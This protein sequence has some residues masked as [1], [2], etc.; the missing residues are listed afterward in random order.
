MV[1]LKKE[2]IEIAGKMVYNRACLEQDTCVP[3]EGVFGKITCCSNKDLC[4]S[5]LAFRSSELNAF[6]FA[7]FTLFFI[8]KNI[9]N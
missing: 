2:V 5:A 6:G 3:S 9:F 1:Y 4:N 8:F 7:L